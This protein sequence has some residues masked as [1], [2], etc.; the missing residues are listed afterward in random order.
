MALSLL[1]YPSTDKSLMF[2]NE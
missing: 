2:C 1:I